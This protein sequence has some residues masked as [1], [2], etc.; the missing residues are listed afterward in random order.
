MRKQRLP[1]EIIYTAVSL[2]KGLVVT[3]VNFWRKK[4]TLMYPEKRWELPDNYRGMPVMPI[5]RKTGKDKCI[6]C[7]SCA[8]ICPEQIIT[9]EHEIGEDKKR[10][11]TEFK[12]D[13]SRCMFCGLCTEVCPTDGLV[14]S[15]HY[16]LSSFSREGMVYDLDNLHE[17]GGFHPDEPE[18]EPAEEECEEEEK[19]TTGGA[20]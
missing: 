10:K 13:M 11:L 1:S 3:F 5:D 16:E 4:V 14:P 17:L 15:E 12:I 18:E 19:P 2:I 6:A 7:G 20:A 8:R 9:I